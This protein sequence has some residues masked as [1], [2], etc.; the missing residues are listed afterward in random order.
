MLINKWLVQLLKV[1]GWIHHLGLIDLKESHSF[2]VTKWAIHIHIALKP[3]F[4]LWV[5]HGIC[6][7][8]D[9]S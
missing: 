7:H 3:G 2:Q 8:K 1:E 6:C 4:T 9:R 5:F